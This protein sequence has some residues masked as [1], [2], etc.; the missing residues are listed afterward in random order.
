MNTKRTTSPDA[1]RRGIPLWVPWGGVGY[2]R[3]TN[4]PDIADYAETNRAT[5][6]MKSIDHPHPCLP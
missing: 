6:A 2:A 3:L 1:Q 5:A 4:I